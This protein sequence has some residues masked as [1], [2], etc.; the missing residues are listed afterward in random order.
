M[1]I[2]VPDYYRD[3]VDCVAGLFRCFEHTGAE[4]LMLEKVRRM[5]LLSS[6]YLRQMAEA[7]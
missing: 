6:G 5:G 3:F 4:E 7:L 2:L 1:K